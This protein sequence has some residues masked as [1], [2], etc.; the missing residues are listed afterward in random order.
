M[1]VVA[2]ALGSLEVL[3]VLCG[4]QQECLQY[5]AVPTSTSHL[6]VYDPVNRRRRRLELVQSVSTDQQQLQQWL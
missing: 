3:L 5:P 1:N 4:V 2:A 6:D